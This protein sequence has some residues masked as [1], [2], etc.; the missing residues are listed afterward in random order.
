MREVG[1]KRRNLRVA[2]LLVIKYL[3]YSQFAIVPVN[4][5][6]FDKFLLDPNRKATRSTVG[7]YYSGVVNYNYRLSTVEM[8]LK[9]SF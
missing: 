5:T 1:W 3:S 9:W 8:L 4:L 6:S 2:R 7:D